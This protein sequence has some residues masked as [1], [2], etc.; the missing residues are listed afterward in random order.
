MRK[1]ETNT[2]RRRGRRQRR[3]R[4]NRKEEDVR[5]GVKEIKRENRE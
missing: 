1:D 4:E 5:K 3:K 2:R